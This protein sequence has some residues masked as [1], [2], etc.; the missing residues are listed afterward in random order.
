MVT[1]SGY[2]QDLAYAAF[3]LFPYAHSST[4]PNLWKKGSTPAK[5]KLPNYA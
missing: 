5:K 4:F 2:T 3:F 1:K